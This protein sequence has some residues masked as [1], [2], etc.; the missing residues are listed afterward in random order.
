M[1]NK[2]TTEQRDIIW[3]SG[4]YL[5]EHFPDEYI[6]WEESQIDGWIEEHKWEPFEYHPVGEILELIDHLA[7]SLRRY[8]KPIE[9]LKV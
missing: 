1:P 6:N 9:A 3:A 7:Y 5:T 8:V 4:H 2:L